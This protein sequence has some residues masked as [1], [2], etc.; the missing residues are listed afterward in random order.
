MKTHVESNG[1]YDEDIKKFAF[2]VEPAFLA[3]VTTQRN[4]TF[5][6]QGW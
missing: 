1:S 4:N 3:Q 2:G 6:T 5:G